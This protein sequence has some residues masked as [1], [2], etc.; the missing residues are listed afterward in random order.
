MLTGCM[1]KATKNSISANPENNLATG[2][3]TH[4]KMLIGGTKAGKKIQN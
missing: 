1:R 4:F 2:F 3:Y